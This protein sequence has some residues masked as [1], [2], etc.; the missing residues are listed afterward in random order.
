VAKVV[1]IW[2]R[3]KRYFQAAAGWVATSISRFS[4]TGLL[5][6]AIA[7]L[8]GALVV[9]DLGRDVV[10]IEP[11]S[12]PKSLSD[13][14]YTPEVAANRVLD[15]M[16]AIVAAQS[17]SAQSTD[18]VYVQSIITPKDKVDFIVPTIGLSLNTIVSSIRSVLHY[19]RGQSISGEI[20]VHD[21]V[22]WL[23][24]R[25]DLQQV[26][27]SSAGVALESLDEHLASAAPAVLEKI[28]PSVAA[29]ALFR[30]HPEQAMQKADDIIARIYASDVNVRFNKSDA[31]VQEAY[32]VKADYF[33]ERQNYA[34]AEKVLR[35]A[36]G[37]NSINSA[38]HVRLGRVLQLQGRLDEAIAEY[39]RAIS[40][41]PGSA[42]AH[43]NLGIAFSQQ[44]KRQQAAAEYRLALDRD[45]KSGSAR[46]NLGVALYNQGKPDDA[47]VQLRRAIEI[48]PNFW[49]LPH[50]NL[51]DALFAQGKIDEAGAE[52]RRAAEVEPNDA[53][54]HNKLGIF[55]GREGKTDDA[56]VEFRR[57]IEIDPKHENAHGNLGQALSRKGQ[58]DEAVAEYR[59]ATEINPKNAA[60]H[61][62]LG[63]ALFN[64]GKDDDA[65][66]EFRS[67]IELGPKYANAHANLGMAL[68]HQGKGD[69]AAA[70]YG[71][72][73][74]IDPDNAIAH[75]GM[76][77]AMSDQGRTDAAIAE[78]R[79]AIATDP[80]Y[81][82]A[83]ENLEKALQT[84]SAAK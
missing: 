70:E 7:L 66:M 71:R 65:I 63:F 83:L 30:E 56:I 72:A 45:P 77:V 47:I 18:E 46:N 62:N 68:Y 59:R 49:A 15:A 40:I 75:N 27:A 80:H 11:I 82:R 25:V 6:I 23:R 50:S 42:S 44:G 26:F 32:A 48:N 54:A 35:T 55:L 29:V 84:K 33:F 17:R 58:A 20:V 52:Y 78:Y 21:N 4:I 57:A 43:N 37:S 39:Q 22:V 3:S 5:S 38:P 28:H 19:R 12:V 2:I 60:V 36:V 16:N 13:T 64:Q 79:R 61:N 14:G 8:V 1:S 76:G 24:L 41:N 9:Q 51:G 73:I 69:A 67:A 53:N 31:V 10:T 34:E 74:E 81:P